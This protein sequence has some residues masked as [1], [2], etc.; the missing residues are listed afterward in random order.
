VATTIQHSILDTS[1]TL[2]VAEH[3]PSRN[4]YQRKYQKN[5]YHERKK[6]AIDMLGG[7]CSSCGTTKKLELDHK[8]PGTKS[9]TITKLW[10]VPEA[11]FKKEVKKCRLLC[12]SCHRKNTSKQRENG[13]VKSV[14]GKTKYKNNRKK[15][16]S[17]PSLKVVLKAFFW[18][19]LDTRTA[20]VIAKNAVS[21]FERLKKKGSWGPLNCDLACDLW[22]K[23]FEAN[24]ITARVANGYYISDQETR[25]LVKKGQLSPPGSS[26]HVWLEINGKIVDP[27]ALQFVDSGPLRVSGYLEEDDLGKEVRG[28]IQL[29]KV[30][31][32]LS[33]KDAA[34]IAVSIARSAVAGH[35]DVD[36]KMASEF[37]KSDRVEHPILTWTVFRKDSGHQLLFRVYG[38]DN[39]AEL[40]KTVVASVKEAF[41]K[42][43]VEFDYEDDLSEPGLVVKTISGICE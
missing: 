26:D 16:S 4:E 9:F 19:S 36:L 6:Q 3:D 11:E 40:I 42:S 15:A 21:V 23:V 18:E 10:S 34:K 7:K 24:G 33:F 38:R 13:T 8:K 35:D 32:T 39:D 37:K 20:D 5:R 25:A 27:T 17:T 14:P 22:S 43:E 29:M 41:S 28:A 2:L 12:N 1:G 30:A 31:S